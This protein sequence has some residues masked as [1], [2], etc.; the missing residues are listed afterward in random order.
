MQELIIELGDLGKMKLLT[1]MILFLFSNLFAQVAVP[2]LKIDLSNGVMPEFALQDIRKL[3][4]V[5]DSLKVHLK[6][7]TSSQE[8]LNE[9][10]KL[11]FED[12]LVTSLTE[13][14]IKFLTKTFE[15]NQNYPNPFNPT[16]TIQYFLPTEG[17]V[18]VKIFNIK[19]NLVKTLFG[20]KQTKGSHKIKWDGKNIDERP[21][22]SGFYIAQVKFGNTIKSKKM[23]LLK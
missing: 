16:T 23:I 9:I 14:E 5:S 22:S 19:G 4:F 6:D 2:G 13:K 10:D 20:D 21:V 15:L 18:E 12:V 8:F 11:F 3:T 7:G 1:L 17:N